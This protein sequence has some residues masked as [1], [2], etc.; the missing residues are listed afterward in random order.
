MKFFLKISKL[1]NLSSTFS[2]LRPFSYLRPF[3]YFDLSTPTSLLRLA[4]FDHCTSTFGK[5]GLL[6][7]RSKYIIGRS[8]VLVEV[9]FGRKNFGLGRSKGQF[10]V[11]SVGR[12]TEKVKDLKIVEVQKRSN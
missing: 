7:Y 10:E 3:L 1:K 12:R 11:K 5:S 2:V 4:Y 9:K 8:K 6:E